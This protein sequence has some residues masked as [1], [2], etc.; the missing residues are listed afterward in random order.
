[1][2][3]YTPTEGSTTFKT[4]QA[5]SISGNGASGAGHD[6]SAVRTKQPK[7]LLRSRSARYSPRMSADSLRPADS[8][9]VADALAYA[10]RYDGNRRVHHADGIMARIA[11][12]HLIRH[13]TASGFVVMRAPPGVAPTTA[14]MPSSIG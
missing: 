7:F 2:E 9:E 14:I 5:G 6:R 10:L 13:L 11:A 3:G 4:T 8:A 1:M 12:D